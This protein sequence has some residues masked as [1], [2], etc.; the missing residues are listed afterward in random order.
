MLNGTG[1]LKQVC[2][3]LFIVPVMVAAQVDTVGIPPPAPVIRDLPEKIP[4]DTAVAD[5]S[6]R[7]SPGTKK[8]LPPVHSPKKAALYSALLPGAGQVYNRKYWKVG[9]LVAGTGALVYGYRFN[10]RYYN[11]FKGELIQRQQTGQAWID[12]GLQ[13]YTNDNL[14]ELQSFYRRNRDLTFIGFALLYA[15]NII[16]AT[17]DAHLFDFDVSDDLSLIVRPQPVYSAVSGIRP[18]IGITFTF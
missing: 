10:T 8:V 7:P 17:V 14:N 18:G 6:S 3:T 9:V 15:A 5:T 2:C 12:P 11:Q 13:R 16:D 1:W 4:L